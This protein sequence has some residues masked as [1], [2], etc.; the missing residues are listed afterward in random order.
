MLSY[1]SHLSQFPQH[2]QYAVSAVEEQE[3]QY[4]RGKL[5]SMLD[6]PDDRVT[7]LFLI[8]FSH[9]SGFCIGGYTISNNYFQ[10]R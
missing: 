5:L 7:F 1:C 8:L 4:L 2:L 3:K 6:E 9:L 10:N